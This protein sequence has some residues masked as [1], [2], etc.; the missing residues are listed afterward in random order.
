MERMPFDPQGWDRGEDGDKTE[1][2]PRA[3]YT[4]LDRPLAATAAA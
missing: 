2:P 4:L 1:P 3:L